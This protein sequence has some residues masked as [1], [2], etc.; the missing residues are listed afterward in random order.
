MRSRAWTG[1]LI[2]WSNIVSS[3]SFDSVC[4][5]RGGSRRAL[6]SPGS[7]G[8][9]GRPAPSGPRGRG[10]G[11][12][13]DRPVIFNRRIAVPRGR[14]TLLLDPTPRG[15]GHPVNSPWIPA[16]AGMTGKDA[17]DC[18]VPRPVT[19]E[20]RKPM[21]SRLRGNDRQCAQCDSSVI[22]A[23]AGIHGSS[24]QYSSATR[25]PIMNAPGRWPALAGPTG[26]GVRR[27][28]CVSGSLPAAAP[29][30]PES[31]CEMARFDTRSTEMTPISISRTMLRGVGGNRRSAGF[32]VDLRLFFPNNDHVRFNIS[33]QD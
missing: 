15:S 23:K 11:T 19:R 22:P 30:T 17:D 14:F 7:E 12:M 18:R 21:D 1:S 32:A 4:G 27:A 20:R 16:F 9:T 33:K 13:A 29:P 24:G 3:K 6:R 10:G 5:P 31:I 28:S 8:C 26:E 25:S 2:V